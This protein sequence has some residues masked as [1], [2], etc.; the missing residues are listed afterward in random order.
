MLNALQPNARDSLSQLRSRIRNLEWREEKLLGEF[1]ERRGGAEGGLDFDYEDGNDSYKKGFYSFNSV[2]LKLPG[3]FSL[4]FPTH[5]LGRGYLT[6][7]YEQIHTYLS[8]SEH[9]LGQQLCI[10]IS[11]INPV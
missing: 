5:I 4:R 10:Q 6:L 11:L 1:P 9:M 3:P 8:I 7:P 2:F